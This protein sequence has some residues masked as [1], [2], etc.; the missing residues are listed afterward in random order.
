MSV[1]VLVVAPAVPIAAHDL[2]RTQVRLTFARDGSFVLEVSNDPSWLKLRL[3][4]FGGNFLDRVVLWVDGHEIRPLSIEYIPGED[5]AT[6]RMRG[7]VPIDARTLRWYYGLVIDPYPLAIR[8]ADGRVIV[9]EVQGDAWSGTIDLSGEFKAPLISE[10]AA[11]VFVVALVIV[12][13]VI[14][15]GTALPRRRARKQTVATGTK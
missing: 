11:L 9:E 15:F 4:R 1:G 2:E 10:R 13:L 7:R 5:L 8:R 6:H 14:R 12:P 3:E